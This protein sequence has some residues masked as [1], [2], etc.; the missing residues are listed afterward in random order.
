MSRR[1]RKKAQTREAI[2]EAA[3]TLF[4]QKGYGGTRT[5]EI[6]EAAGIATGTLFNYAPT[7]EAVVL[8]VWKARATSLME[9]GLVAA[10]ASDDPLE[11]ILA[12]FVPI[13][14]FYSEDL[15]LGRLFLQQATYA[16]PNDPEMVALSEGFVARIAMFLSPHAGLYALHA[17]I[18]VFAAYHTVLTMLLGG[19]I[20][21]VSAA[22]HML[23]DL[24]T[25]QISG[26][27][28]G[29]STAQ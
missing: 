12:L 13:F 5:R 11:G 15:E 26:W 2:I 20:A 10:S 28:G 8:L 21:D 27:R 3:R 17:A 23:R 6:A 1:E 19:R 24:L 18:N 29:L 14:S 9:S 25:V 22:E 16:P 7:K 4:E